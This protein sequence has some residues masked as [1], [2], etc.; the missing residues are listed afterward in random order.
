MEEEKS[1]I[2]LKI[3]SEAGNKNIKNWMAMGIDEIQIEIFWCLKD[4]NLGELCNK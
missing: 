1:L 3:W 2:L 4:N